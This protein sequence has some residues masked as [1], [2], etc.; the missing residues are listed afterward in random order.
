[1]NDSTLRNELDALVN[2]FDE[3]PEHPDIDW[4][5]YRQ[6]TEL[7]EQR[8]YEELTK[9]HNVPGNPVCDVNELMTEILS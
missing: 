7:Q 5:R 4:E 2:A 9:P 1:M 3:H 6:I 8:L